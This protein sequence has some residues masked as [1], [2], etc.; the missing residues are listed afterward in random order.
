MD[1]VINSPIYQPFQVWFDYIGTSKI[2]YTVRAACLFGNDFTMESVI[3]ADKS[4]EDL[5][6]LFGLTHDNI[7]K[8]KKVFQ[9]YS[10]MVYNETNFI[11]ALDRAVNCYDEEYYQKYMYCINVYTHAGVANSK[12]KQFDIDLD[13]EFR[14]LFTKLNVITAYSW[15]SSKIVNDKK[16]F[17]DSITS[18]ALSDEYEFQDQITYATLQPIT[19]NIVTPEDELFG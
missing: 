18:I 6:V 10:R 1:C 9:I 19:Q 11:E 13:D 2:E 14:Y 12:F 3:Y 7:G 4:S 5:R 17:I 8:K 16:S 15:D